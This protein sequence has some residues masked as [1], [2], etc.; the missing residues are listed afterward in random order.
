MSNKV[1]F[2][3]KK[4]VDIRHPSW[5]R[6]PR[7]Q[8]GRHFFSQPLICKWECPPS[9]ALTCQCPHWRAGVAI[10]L[11]VTSSES[12]S[13]TEQGKGHTLHAEILCILGRLSP[14]RFLKLLTSMMPM[15]SPHLRCRSTLPLPVGN[16]GLTTQWPFNA[17]LSHAYR[18][19]RPN[20]TVRFQA[21]FC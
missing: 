3:G 21:D 5:C 2:S 17:S 1:S 4:V 6:H 7:R 11:M 18:C 13:R 10:S 15:A 8:V 19:Q 9:G 20:F 16:S 12:F 14:G